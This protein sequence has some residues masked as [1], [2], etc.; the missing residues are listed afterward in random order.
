[1]EHELITQ[2][3]LARRHGVSKMAVTK[4]RQRGWISLTGGL[5]DAGE[6]ARSL[7]QH[8]KPTQA[9]PVARRIDPRAH[10]P[11]QL[12]RAA[13]LALLEALDVRCTPADCGPV[14][15]EQGAQAVGMRATLNPSTGCF[16][17]A[18]PDGEVVAGGGFTLDGPAAL[19]ACRLAIA[20]PLHRSEVEVTV[21][22]DL[23]PALARPFG[24]AHKE[25][26]T[27]R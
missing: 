2:A 9:R 11:V 21:R 22:L 6:A 1:M 25:S 19:E 8:R 12:A 24:P 14:R 4:W 18:L 20:S 5:V 27:A 17:L 23:L 16:Q 15:V 13:V 26:V 10:Q 7:Q 3:E